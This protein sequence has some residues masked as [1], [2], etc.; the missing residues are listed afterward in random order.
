MSGLIEIL[1][2]FKSMFALVDDQQFQS[3]LGNKGRESMLNEFDGSRMT[4]NWV[5][6]YHECLNDE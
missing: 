6:Y 5:D 1:K 4:E 3:R 2:K